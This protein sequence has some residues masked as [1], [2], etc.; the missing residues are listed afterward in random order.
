MIDFKSSAT[1]HYNDAEYL[2][3][4][5]RHANAGQLFG[6]CAECGLKALL[7]SQGYPRNQDGSPSKNRKQ[8]EAHNPPLP[9]I[10]IHINE[11]Q[12]IFTNI[13]Q[14]ESGR[15]ANYLAMIEQSITNFSDWSTDH[16]YYAENKIPLS[17]PQWQQAARNAMLM[18]QQATIDGV[19]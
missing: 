3:A 1:R 4:D 5:N 7:I 18:L 9:Y 19:L 11:L 16:R 15:G 6:F 14:W 10:R 13:Q 8:L 12:K 17:L 2:T